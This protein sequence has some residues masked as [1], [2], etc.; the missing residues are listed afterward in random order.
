MLP[1]LMSQQGTWAPAVLCI[2]SHPKYLILG[3]TECLQV[4]ADST[5]VQNQINVRLSISEEGKEATKIRDNP[6]EQG[7]LKQAQSLMRSQLT[8]ICLQPCSSYYIVHCYFSICL[9]HCGTR[10]LP[11][12]VRHRASTK[13]VKSRSQGHCPRVGVVCL[14]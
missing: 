9:K 3:M 12:N 8:L 4:I 5:R 11:Q 2:A 14:E 13:H 6:S 10:G 1:E 7:D